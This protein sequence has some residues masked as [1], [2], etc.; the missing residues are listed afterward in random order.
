MLCPHVNSF[1][2]HI[3]PLIFGWIPFCF[4]ITVL[5][6][7][8]I[9]ITVLFSHPSCSVQRQDSQ[10]FSIHRRSLPLPGAPHLLHTTNAECPI[11]G[12]GS[13]DLEPEFPQDL[14]ASLNPGSSLFFKC[15][16]KLWPLILW[17]VEVWTAHSC[18]TLSDPM[19]CC[20]PG[21]TVHRILHARILEW[22]A[23]SFFRGSSQPM[24]WICVSTFQADSSEPPEKLS[25]SLDSHSVLVSQVLTQNLI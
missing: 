17:E 3:L 4:V 6:F 1:R 16:V 23:I 19:D 8:N 24:D 14:E 20:S 11:P 12:P 15:I 5:L 7:L 25:L 2:K 22:V 9:Y 10:K 18:L 21:S 13:D